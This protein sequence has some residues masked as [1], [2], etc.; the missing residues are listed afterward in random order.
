MIWMDVDT[1]LSEVP[2]NVAP[3]TDDTDFKST[4]EAVAYNAAGMDLE[5]HFITT[6]GAYTVTAVTPTSAGTYDWAHQGNGMYSI[7]IPASGG[8]S[9]NND[10]EGHGYFVGK[11]TGV[12]PWRGPTIGFRAA[13]INDKL[14]DSAYD[15][16]RG[17]AGTALPANPYGTSG[18]LPRHQDVDAILTDTNELQ[19]DWTNGGRLDLLIDAILAD[20]AEL[21]TDWTNGGRLDLLLDATL[22]DTNELQTDWVNGGRLDL[23]I[24]SIITGVATAN[25]FLNAQG[26]TSLGDILLDTNAILLDTNEL[27]TDWANGGRLDLLLDATLADTNE[28]QTDWA[29][30]GR[31][32]LLLDATLADTNELQTDWANGGRLDL[33]VDAIIADLP[34]RITKNTA[35]ANFMFKMVDAT[36]HVTAET[37]LTVTAT[38]SLDGAAFGACANSVSEVASGWYKIDL[39]AGDLN[40]NV[41]V[42]RFTATGADTAEFL[43]VT[44]PT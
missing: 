36:D 26:M 43:I 15:S 17:L 21:Q 10:T 40:G 41:V 42:L 44:Q 13:G 23:L 6:G 8:A 16:D 20:T 11:A 27:Q 4:E 1:A 30:G 18:G 5:W 12:L 32:D 2:V 24:D 37:G 29:N 31:L 39:A 33:L 34:S 35:L 9:I 22:A 38:R 28:L 19:T 7:E 3:L 25:T 14:I